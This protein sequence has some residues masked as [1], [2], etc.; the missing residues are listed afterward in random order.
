MRTNPPNELLRLVISFHPFDP[1]CSVESIDD[2]LV[3]YTHSS[4]QKKLIARILYSYST[5][6]ELALVQD[7]HRQFEYVFFVSV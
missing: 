4:R 6:S 3:A 1:R 7:S 5:H 2:Q